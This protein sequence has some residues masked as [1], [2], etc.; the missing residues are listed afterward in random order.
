M[1]GN[2]N[3][4]YDNK[5]GIKKALSVIV[6]FGLVSLF[7]DIVYEGARSV[8]GPYLKLLA[9][10]AATLGLISGFGE[11]LGYAL[12]LVSGYLAD[13]TK[14][15]WFLTFLGYGLLISVPLLSLAGVWQVAAVLIILERIGKAIRSPARDTILSQA[16][17]QVGRGFGFGLHEAM[18]QIGAIAGPLIFA[19]FFLTAGKNAGIA[20]Y[21]KG[22]TFL[23]IPFLLVMACLFISYRQVPAPQVLE[24]QSKSKVSDTLSK[25]FWLY[26]LFTFFATAGFC[27]FILIAFHFKLTGVLTDAQ[28]PL[29]YAIAM[30][31]D[32]IAALAIGKSYDLL[33]NKSRN[34]N[35]G[36]NLLVVIPLLSIIM[37]FFAFSESI[38]FIIIGLSFW[39]V[40]MGI[41]ETIM[42]SAIAD[43][44]SLKKRGTGYGIFNTT[45][46]VAIF[47]GSY[48]FGLLYDRSLSL[49]FLAV[50]MLELIAFFVFMLMRREILRKNANGY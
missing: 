10:N 49:V 7:G 11:L 3:V 35:A 13:K 28:I 31:V 34:T 15:Y 33:S 25:T 6:L 44:T 12:R 40:I 19:A 43:I 16:S 39:G 38:F 46:G 47:L 1:A 42:R 18:D 17:S 37:P 26:N 20:E 27:S 32:A 4:S 14:S 30:G 45:Y 36:L 41:Q 2:L 8:N 48:L 29:F 24:M 22:Y 21:Q 5:S 9:V 50:I 23:W